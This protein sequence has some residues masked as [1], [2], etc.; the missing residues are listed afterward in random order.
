MSFKIDDETRLN[1]DKM[2]KESGASDNT[3]KIRKLRHSSKI[4]EQ[5]SIMMDIRKNIND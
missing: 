1:F 4:N 5:V 3:A 2:L